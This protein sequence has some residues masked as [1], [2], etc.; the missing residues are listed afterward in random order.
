[1]FCPPASL[2]LPGV[3]KYISLAAPK[4][5][6]SSHRGDFRWN[7]NAAEFTPGR[8]IGGLAGPGLGRAAVSFSGL[9]P[10]MPSCSPECGAYCLR[11]GWIQRSTNVGISPCQRRA[12]H[13]LNTSR[14]HRCQ[15]QK[16]S[17]MLPTLHHTWSHV[18]RLREAGC[19]LL[20]DPSR[21]H[22]LKANHDHHQHQPS[23]STP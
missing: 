6:L 4:T 11:H 8:I 18:A 17:H 5:L 2:I 14:C 16:G 20:L 13:E 10:S 22:A 12:A 9:R 3:A 19:V 23:A 1:M 7:L 15:L 21:D